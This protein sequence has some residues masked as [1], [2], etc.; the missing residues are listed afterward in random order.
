[1]IAVILAA[2]AMLAQDI[3]SVALVQAEARSRAHLSAVLDT[4]G[5]LVNVTTVSISVVTLAGHDTARK[6]AVILAVSAANYLGTYMGVRIGKR[7][8]NEGKAEQ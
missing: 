2:V 3:I 7:Y 1:M 8:V 4:V 5:W 6:I